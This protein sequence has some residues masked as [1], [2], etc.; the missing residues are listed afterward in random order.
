MVVGDI[1]Q[2]RDLV[3]IG[4]G[5]GGYNAAIRAAQLGLQV[6]LVEKADMGGV[7]LNK[8]CIP[9][10]VHTHAAKQLSTLSKLED[11]GISTKESSF[12][13]GKLSSYKEKVVTNLRK[14]VESLCQANKIEILKG[15]AS[16]IS[17]VR[18]GV[19][20]G[21]NFDIIQFK[22]AIIA[23]G[24]TPVAEGPLDVS[25]ERILLSHEIYSLSEVPEHLVVYGSD[26][27]SLEVASSYHYLG[28]KVTIVLDD[29]KDDF[30]FDD[31]INRELKRLLKKSKIKVLRGHTIETISGSDTGVEFVCKKGEDA[32]TVSGTHAFLS[33]KNQPNIS[34]LGLD[35][36]GVDVSEAGYVVTDVTMKTSK[37][38][39][40]AIG[41]TTEGE[42]LAIKAIKQ[43]KVAAETIAGE[44]SEVD[45]TFLPIVVHTVPPI[46]TVGLTE[47]EAK[48]AGYEVKTGQFALGG[49]G[50]AMITGEKDGFV[51][52][53]KD[54]KTDML[55]GFHAIGAGAVEMISTG[56]VALEMVGRDE[57]LTFPLYPHPSF[58][59]AFLEAVEG[60]SDQA[61]H[62]PPAKK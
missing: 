59:E 53:I 60:L 62:S 15:A 17:E 35:R 19:E 30:N 13:F 39:I 10:K 54:S 50:Y 24:A 46:A 2:E 42:S 40:F 31:S 52:V 21:H 12:D 48:E 6:T 7:C 41:D 25:H 14:G 20:E 58:N 22:H 23:T 27:L 36:I 51:K 45:L 37:D 11:I 9:S 57:D 32:E 28:A 38:N 34:S 3:I 61:I 1:V 29:A 56:T 5:P 18:I 4:G 44:A 47:K 49:N 26:Y 33:T 16:F 43:G 55:L 8:G